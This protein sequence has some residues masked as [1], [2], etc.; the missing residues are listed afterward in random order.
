MLQLCKRSVTRPK[1]NQWIKVFTTFVSEWWVA[2]M[3]SDENNNLEQSAL[4]STEAQKKWSQKMNRLPH[5]SI[6]R[7]AHILCQNEQITR[8]FRLTR[9]I[10]RVSIRA[11]LSA[12]AICRTHEKSYSAEKV[13][14]HWIFFFQ[15]FIF[16]YERHLW[17]IRYM[18][19]AYHRCWL[20]WPERRPKRKVSFIGHFCVGFQFRFVL[21]LPKLILYTILNVKF[22]P[23]WKKFNCFFRKRDLLSRDDLVLPWKPLYEIYESIAYSKFESVGLKRHS[24]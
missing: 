9:V 6:T 16:I 8:P 11:N 15:S 18:S 17:I 12:R 23:F 20:R 22:L 21:E 2:L 5:C 7:T 10:A 14:F 3:I 19:I 24:W 4:R 13:L 1:L